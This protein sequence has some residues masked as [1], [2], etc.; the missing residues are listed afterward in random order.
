M[1]EINAKLAAILVATFAVFGWITATGKDKAQ[2]VRLVDV[3]V[4]GP[5]LIYIG[6]HPNHVLSLLERVFLVFIGATTV[7]YNL[8]NYLGSRET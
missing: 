3:F 8:R 6:L 1:V 4:Y 7:T 5:F 2:W